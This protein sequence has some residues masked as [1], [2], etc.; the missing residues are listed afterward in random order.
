MNNTRINIRK[1]ILNL[2]K[3]FC[4]SDLFNIINSDK[5]IDN[6]LIIQVLNELYD[7]E[8][9]EYNKIQP[10]TMEYSGYAFANKSKVLVKKI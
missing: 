4:I 5:K 9:I 8:L 7:E 1:Q 6:G 2:N 3:P 10:P